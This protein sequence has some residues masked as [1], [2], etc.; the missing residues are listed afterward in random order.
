MQING[1][2][3]TRQMKCSKTHLKKSMKI[4]DKIDYQIGRCPSFCLACIHISA[5]FHPLQCSIPEASRDFDA[6]AWPLML[7]QS[8]AH[9]DLAARSW[10]VSL[11]LLLVPLSSFPNVFKSTKSTRINF[12]FY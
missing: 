8:L 2:M 9:P 6:G 5:S 10:K 7:P 4:M 1:V 3:I 11:Q 12:Y